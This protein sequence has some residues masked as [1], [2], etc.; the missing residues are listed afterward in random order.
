MTARRFGAAVA[1]LLVVALAACTD[2][3]GLT[4]NQRHD[5]SSFRAGANSIC[6]AATAAGHAAIAQAKAEFP[7]A[8]T[9]DQAHSFLVTTV[10]P[11]S[12][13]EVGDLHNL[14]EPT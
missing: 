9:V 1:L 4:G 14:G 5:I 8:P 2:D 11:I 7:S 10:I 12:D 6:A 13:R 3:D